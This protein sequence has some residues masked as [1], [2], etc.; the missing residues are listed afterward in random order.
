MQLRQTVVT[1]SAE[2]KDQEESR[3]NMLIYNL[4]DPQQNLKGELIQEDLVTLMKIAREVLNLNLG[5]DDITQLKRLGEKKEGMS[6]PLL[7][8]LADERNKESIFKKLGRLQGS[9]FNK[10]SFTHDMTN[11]E[12]EQKNKLVTKAKG[13]EAEAVGK[14][15]YRVRG[16][17]WDMKIIKKARPL[18]VSQNSTQN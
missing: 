6:K 14:W 10:V 11:L 8:S 4:P 15:R 16:P 13:L 2:M 1:V 5:K 17:P 12:R 9:E 18:P 7:I 3:N